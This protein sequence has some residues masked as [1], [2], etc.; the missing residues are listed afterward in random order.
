MNRRY[1]LHHALTQQLVFSGEQI[2]HEIVT[3]FI[4]IARGAG[5][6]MIDSHTRRPAEIIRNGKNFVGWFT[7]A[8]QPLRVRTRGADRKQLR[9]N[10]DKSGKE[11][12]LAIEFRAEPRHGV[13]QSA[14][15]SLAR[16]RGVIDVAQKYFVQIVDI[17]RAICAATGA[18][19]SRR[20]IFLNSERLSRDRTSAVAC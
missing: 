8:E 10:T 13:K 4:G 1:L 16:A 7:L 15:K 18:D 12:L 17:A 3:A 14:R 5:E 20:K 2:L 6:M 19:T 11:Q 9:G